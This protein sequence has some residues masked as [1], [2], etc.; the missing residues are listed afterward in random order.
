MIVAGIDF[1]TTSVDPE[2]CHPT[3]IALVLWEASTNKIIEPMSFLLEIPADV[4]ITNEHITGISKRLTQNYGYR[5]QETQAYVLQRLVYA[6]YFMAHNVEFDRTILKRMFD[7]ESHHGEKPFDDSHWIDTMTDIPYPD[8]IRTRSLPYLAAEH[9]FLNPFPHRA[10]FDVMTM[11]KIAGM[12]DFADILTYAQSPTIWIQAVVS[13]AD[14]QKAKDRH[15]IWDPVNKYWV[16]KIKELNLSYE[17]ERADFH[18][19]LL[20]GYSYKEQYL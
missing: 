14:R 4:E 11:I 20:P 7:W 12:Y 8:H 10:L 18:I 2:T 9:G 1:E 15:F 6:D 19:D 5:W 17:E 3:E 16:K 13:M